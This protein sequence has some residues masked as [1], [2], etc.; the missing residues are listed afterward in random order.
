MAAELT[1]YLLREFKIE[2]LPNAREDD[3]ACITVGALLR[4]ASL[5]TQQATQGAEPVAEVYRL[6]YGGRM[7]NIGTNAIRQLVPSDKLPP[8]GTKLYAAS[9][10]PPTGTSQ[11][12]GAS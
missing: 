11:G 9:P 7:R 6:H 8:P 4:L 1:D 12:E 10:T 2:V 3:M 5:A